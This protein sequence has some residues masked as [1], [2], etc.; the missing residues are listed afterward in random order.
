MLH[1]ISISLQVSG[2]I[3]LLLWSFSGIKEEEIIRKY[4]P[5]SNIAD[6]DD[7]GFCILNKNKLQTIMKESLKNI[8]AFFYIIFGYMLTYFSHGNDVCPAGSIV[9]TLIFSV[10]MIILGDYLS[11]LIA[12]MIYRKDLRI[13]YSK[14]SP[15]GID[16]V[17]KDSEINKLF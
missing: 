6:R 11:G 9:L 8:I 2:A 1:I 16:T 15:F 12:K 5:G 7:E 4:F 14:L 17:A 10:G 13:H 3:I